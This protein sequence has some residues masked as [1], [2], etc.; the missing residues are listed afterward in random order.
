LIKVLVKLRIE[1]MYLNKIKAIHHKPISNVTLK[2]EKLKP[3]P[4]KH[5][6][7]TMVFILSIN[8]GHCLQIPRQRNKARKIKIIQIG[9]EE[10]KFSYLQ[11]TLSY[12]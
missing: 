8:T 3:F 4:L 7:E 12:N 9:K 11:M 10:V 1:G 6:N 5:E 2:G